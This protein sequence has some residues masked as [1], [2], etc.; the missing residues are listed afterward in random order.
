MGRIASSVG[1]IT[2]TDI[3]GTVDQLIAISAQ[4]RDRLL[5]QINTLQ[6]QQQAYAELTAS[7]IGVQLAGDQ[8]SSTSLFRSKSAESSN[9]EALSVDTTE[10]A[11]IAEHLVNTIQLAATHS[12]NS[13]QRFE[14]ADTELGLTG[15]ISISPGGFVDD[16]V[17]LASLNG[18]LGVDLGTI[19]VTDRSGASAEIDL[20]QA[21]TFD[22]VLTA[23]N[24]A[25]VGVRA[26]TEGNAIKLIDETGSTAS[27]LIVEQLGNNET[28]ADLGLWGINEASSSVVGNT[29][30]LPEGVSALRGA[31]LGEL[32][33]GVGIGPLTSID[34]ALSDA[35][36]ATVDLSSATSLSE[37]V[38][39]INA[40]GI[41]VT[42]RLN[43]AKNGLRLRDVSGGT[44]TFS[45]SSGDDTATQLKISGSTD[46]QIITGGNLNRQTVT[47]STLLADLNQG[48]GING[49]S[50]TVT[51]SSGAVSA[52]NI[53]TDEI[54]TVG[55]LID[56]LNDL[57]IGI[58][59]SLNESGDGIAVVD[60][61][62]GGQTL[63]IS[64]T[65]TG[66]AAAD[67]GI[68]GTA[69][70]QTFGGSTVSALIGTESDTIEIEADDT[71][72][73]IVAAI[74]ADGR[75]G[76][77]SVKTNDD[78]TYSLRI[79]SRVGGESG[80]LA[81]N[82]GGL[83]LDFKTDSVGQDA[84]ITLST[85]GGTNR[86]LTS[87]DGV[88]DDENTGL[89]LTLKALSTDPIT[90]SVGKNPDAVTKAAQS[91]VDQYNKLVDKLD[92]LTF[93]NADT[94]E[95]G[96]LFGTSEALRIETGYTRLLSGT[97]RTGSTLRSLGEV[98]IKFNDQGK[99]SL[100]K[101]KLESAISADQD[102]VEK[103]FVNVDDETGV[104]SGLAKKLSSLADRMAGTDGGLL[105][106]R[107][108][109]IGDQIERNSSRVD[110][111]NTRLDAERERLLSQ[112]IATEQA[113]AKLQ[114]NQ[115][116]ISQI[117]P[118]SIAS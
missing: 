1:L 61:A 65:G 18:G 79:R 2:G 76:D 6:Q 118:I 42:A 107:S 37:V 67:L 74:N 116:Y 99:L 106:N 109:T 55:E 7:V 93:F 3:V 66:T 112:F 77:A 63:S 59:A 47:E 64:D 78:G 57:D 104:D 12:V 40:S 81:I 85:D 90:V 62:G 35:T 46:D 73:D 101:S 56:K 32:G 89:N 70:E 10:D 33:G 30:E 87:S 50:F 17:Q 49:G 72:E 44:G 22:D 82:T 54:T 26:T 68:A 45:V 27:N 108:E 102:A 19:R 71:L 92:S 24:D 98:G 43:D 21:R 23:I 111:L 117:Q 115:T 11:A 48:S 110:T 84:I 28:T 5:S 52:V 88:F 113:I 31:S 15:S 39:A 94:D 97:I 91:F 75:Y 8:L 96:L 69:T 86:F 114:E 13:L 83:D 53:T 60:T 34:I 95:I 58:T 41:D 14:A 16:S 20:T 29:L 36:T 80:R 100:D 25:Q 4:P 51:D 38:D 105:L 9:S 103:F